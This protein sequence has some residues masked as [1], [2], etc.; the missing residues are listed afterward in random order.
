MCK[1]RNQKDHNQS[2]LEDLIRDYPNNYF[3]WKITVLFYIS[4]HL[5]RD[6][7]FKKRSVEISKSHRAVF[8]FL[9]QETS[10]SSQ[11]YKSFSILFRNCRDCRYNGF[12]TEDA[13]EKFCE[14]KFNESQMHLN[15]IEAYFNSQNS[16]KAS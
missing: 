11:V 2:F 16:K 8:E 13:F 9:E 6:F 1:H 12:T 14:V 4:I 10:K 7:A 15:K 5:I 3:D